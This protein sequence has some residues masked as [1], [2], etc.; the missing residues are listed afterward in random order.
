MHKLFLSLFLAS[1][2]SYAAS[3]KPK[4]HCTLS[5]EGSFIVTWQAFK[6]PSKVPVSGSFDKVIYK[7]A[8]AEGINFKEIF[9]GSSVLIDKVSV[10]TKN[11]GRDAKLVQFFFN[12]IKGENIQAKILSVKSDPRVKG[13]PKTGLFVTEVT[14]NGITKTVPMHFRFFKGT[15][16]AEG[17][18]DLF[19][20]QANTAL[21]ELNKACFEKHEGKTWNDVK[22]GFTT[23]IKAL[24]EAIQ[25]K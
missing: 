16:S 25:I 12:M 14:M 23:H 7:A 20:F 18:I 9:T 6:T 19:D 11:K 5:Q 21:S 10:N 8:K 17:V 1:T 22:I 2:L 24:C 15:L 13:K 4:M 3:D